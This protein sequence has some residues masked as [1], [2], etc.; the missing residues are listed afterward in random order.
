MQNNM[1][2]VDEMVRAVRNGQDISLVLEAAI[3]LDELD[4]NDFRPANVINRLK[5]AGNNFLYGSKP[6]TPS[7][8]L[9]QG[10][11]TPS[12]PSKVTMAA[13]GLR[14]LA[15]AAKQAIRSKNV[16]LDKMSGGLSHVDYTGRPEPT[17]PKYQRAKTAGT[18]TGG[19][20]SFSGGPG[21][22][23]PMDPYNTGTAGNAATR[24]YG[25]YRPDPNEPPTWA[26]MAGATAKAADSHYTYGHKSSPFSSTPTSGRTKGPLPVGFTYGTPMGTAVKAARNAGFKVKQFQ[27]AKTGVSMDGNST[28]DVHSQDIT[29]KHPDGREIFLGRSMKVRPGEPGAEVSPKVR[30]RFKTPGTDPEAHQ[31]GRVFIPTLSKGPLSKAEKAIHAFLSTAHTGPGKRRD[32][33]RTYEEWARILDTLNS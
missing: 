16:P 29:L 31:I 4:W 18:S 30:V 28:K 32:V 26:N 1:S 17:N 14:V 15:G 5:T 6:M 33:S 24:T 9:A 19:T 20:T 3:S 22:P 10:R 23:S 2:I 13:K 11:K 12:G 25:R 8:Y 27:A 21:K 7:E